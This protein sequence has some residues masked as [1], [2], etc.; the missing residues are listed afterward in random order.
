MN[1]ILYKISPLVILI[2]LLSFIFG[3]SS[4][5]KG[6]DGYRNIKIVELEGDATIT[7]KEKEYDAYVN[8]SLRSND[9]ILVKEASSLI[10]KLDSDKYLYV[11]EKSN[12][13]LV[14]SNKD[15]SKTLIK[16]NEGSIVSEVKNKLS[17]FEEFGVETPNSTMAIRGTTFG[18]SVTKSNDTI[19]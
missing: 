6:Q 5:K 1:K 7:R 14:S 2:F 10:L 11:G 17:D 3:L 9:N 19:L 4:C 16:V 18:I 13:D 12:I 15:S 8:M